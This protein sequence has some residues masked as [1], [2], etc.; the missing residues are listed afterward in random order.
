MQRCHAPSLPEPDRAGPSPAFL[1]GPF[2]I[3]PFLIGP[4]LI[5]QV[6]LG[7]ERSRSRGD[8][9]ATGPRAPEGSISWDLIT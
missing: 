5:G 1:I 3:G 6:R 4:F 8:R 2:L 7:L 9:F